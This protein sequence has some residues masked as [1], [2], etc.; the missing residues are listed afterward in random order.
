MAY[1]KDH[2]GNVFWV[3]F[4]TK[5]GVRDMKP[6]QNLL[7]GVLVDHYGKNMAEFEEAIRQVH[8]NGGRGITYFTADSL[9]D[10]HLAIIKKYNELYNR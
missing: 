5:Q 4:A 8:D 3:G 6:G 9:S 1:K 10:A 7:S 2:G